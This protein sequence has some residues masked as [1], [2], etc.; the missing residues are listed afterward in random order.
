MR[1][2]VNV[3]IDREALIDAYH[4]F[5][6]DPRASR[7]DHHRA[8]LQGGPLPWDLL[9]VMVLEGVTRRADV[10]RVVS[11]VDGMTW[12]ADWRYTA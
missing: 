3:Q 6:T 2:E 7:R 9:E 5:V 1:V 12:R 10:A 8:T 11:M 4:A